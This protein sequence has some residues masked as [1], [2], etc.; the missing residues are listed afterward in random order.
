VVTVDV[1]R[2]APHHLI[3]DSALAGGTYTVRRTRSGDAWAQREKA[4]LTG[5][6]DHGHGTGGEAAGPVVLGM[7]TR[8]R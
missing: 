7:P 3:A 1:T 6:D 4:R 5:G 8:R 2:S